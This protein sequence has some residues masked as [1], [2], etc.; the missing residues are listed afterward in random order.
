MYLMK[1]ILLIPVPDAKWNKIPSREAYGNFELLLDEELA[2]V[3]ISNKHKHDKH[4]SQNH[5]PK[6]K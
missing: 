5:L 6:W 1:L 2:G 4:Q 3:D